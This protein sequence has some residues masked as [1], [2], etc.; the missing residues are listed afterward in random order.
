MPQVTIAAI[1]MNADP[2]PIPARLQRAAALVQQAAASGAQLVVLPELFNT[3]Y[4]YHENNYTLPE[5]IDGQ[6]ITW[7][8]QTAAQHNL[9]LTG[10]LFLLDGR[11]VYNSQILVAPDGRRWRYD[12]NYPFAFERAYFRDGT[13]VTVAHTDLGKFGMMVCWDYA[14]PEIWQRYAGKV[15]AIIITSS[16][17]TMD[18]FKL[19]MP[20]NQKV[21]SRALGPLTNR[22]HTGDSPF[23][24]D[25]DA[26]LGWL[27]VPGVNTTATGTFSMQLLRPRLAAT[28]YL[29]FRPDLWRFIWQGEQIELIAGYYH[30]TKIVGADGQV[31]ARAGDTEGFTIHTVSLPDATPTAPATP[32][33]ELPYANSVYFFADHFIP[34][35]MEKLY[36]EGIRRQWGQRMAPFQRSIRW[37]I[38]LGLGVVGVLA[39]LVR[40]IGYIA[41]GRKKA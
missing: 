21:D 12:K 8:K 35:L 5:P 38:V 4:E 41:G 18:R 26:Q 28:S 16:P 25:I 7:M 9:H 27:G 19:V 2:A 30:Q 24:A 23:G 31:R 29:A 11:D 13:D 40:G 15:D 10:S 34:A 14:H 36:R 22:A 32:Q 33:P 6:T 20:N 37:S 17:P 3:G 1:Q 39:A